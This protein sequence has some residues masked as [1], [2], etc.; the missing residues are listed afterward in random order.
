[1]APLTLAPGVPAIIL[2]IFMSLLSTVLSI[3]FF[4]PHQQSLTSPSP[5]RRRA[6]STTYASCPA[7][8]TWFFTKSSKKVRAF[9]TFLIAVPFWTWAALKIIR[10]GDPDL[11]AVTFLLVMISC[12]ITICIHD[13]GTCCILVKKNDGHGN[14]NIKSTT[15][16]TSRIPSFMLIFANGL[17]SLNYG[18]PLFFMHLPFT[19]NLY[20]VIGAIYWAIMG[21]WNWN[22]PLMILDDSE[23][24]NDKE[25]GGRN[26]T[27][28]GS[29]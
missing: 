19:F 29:T 11:G 26:I 13:N 12:M 27:P 24:D 9:G 3:R 4:Y 20:L 7:P 6:A 21:I 8:L 17:L 28:Y 18:L 25:N 1:M 5:T 14:T 2:L 10:N 22:A 16:S 23:E 15:S